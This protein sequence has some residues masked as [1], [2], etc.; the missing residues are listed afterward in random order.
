[1]HVTPQWRLGRKI[2]PHYHDQSTSVVIH[3]VHDLDR[4]APITSLLCSAPFCFYGRDYAQG[5]K[6]Y[7]VVRC[8]TSHGAATRSG[9]LDCTTTL[10]NIG[11]SLDRVIH[12]CIDLRCVCMSLILIFRC[13][14]NL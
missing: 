9:H 13:R 14:R 2:H 11:S 5:W 1:M 7:V 6:A 4:H 3:L 10:L 12:T 8:G